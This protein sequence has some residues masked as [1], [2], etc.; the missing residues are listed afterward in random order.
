MKHPR[1]WSVFGAFCL[2]AAAASLAMIH[3]Q[4]DDAQRFSS[5]RFLTTITDS[6]GS[7]ASRSVIT[8]NAD[9]TLSAIDS[10]EGSSTGPFGAQAGAWKWDGGGR[11]VGRVIDFR[12]PPVSTSAS[13][14]RS[15][16]ALTL[17][18]DGRSLTGTIT[19]YFYPLEGSNPLQGLGTLFGTF[20]VVGE[21]IAP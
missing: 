2:I 4:Q 21:P 11:I 3:A 7:F 6:E 16:Y 20:N 17:A 9:G 1:L 14:A 13:I 5:G 19:V 12:Y 18:P 15:D 8:L 10:N